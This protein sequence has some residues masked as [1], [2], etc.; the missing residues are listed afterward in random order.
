[1]DVKIDAETV[2]TGSTALGGI[3]ALWAAWMAFAKRQR[4][5]GE[6][7]AL[8]EK[9]VQDNAQD[10]DTLR[11]EYRDDIAAIRT[12]INSGFQNLTKLI[13]ERK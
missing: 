12:D 5:K 6:R 10:L 2:A 3:G 8:M 4:Q 13:I 9:A 7:W 11:Q 1:M